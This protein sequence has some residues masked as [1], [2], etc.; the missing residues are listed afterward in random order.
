MEHR[1]HNA[2]GVTGLFG[3]IGKI[4]YNHRQ[5]LA[6]DIA[7][8]I[9]LFGNGKAGKLQARIFK[10]GLELVPLILLSA[11]GAHAL[12]DGSNHFLVGGAIGLEG[13]HEGHG[14]VGLIN[15]GDDIVVEGFG[16]HNAAF[17]Q[18]VVEQLLLQGGNEAAEDVA[19]AKMHPH[20]LLFGLFSHSLPVEGGQGDVGGGKGLLVL[21]ALIAQ[22]HA[23]IL[24]HIEDRQRKGPLLSPSGRKSCTG[25]PRYR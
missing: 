24:L 9:A 17:A 20:G 7:Q 22:F 2:H 11:A 8:S 25:S 12:G 23:D 6:L 18:A 10:N 1:S 19:R 15:F 5:Q 16:S 13:H 14:I 21:N 3:A 4:G